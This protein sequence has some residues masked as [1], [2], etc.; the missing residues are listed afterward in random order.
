M[1]QNI[2]IN[3]IINDK[4]C[5]S[6]DIPSSIQPDFVIYQIR[7]KKHAIR[8]NTFYL[9]AN[10]IVIQMAKKRGVSIFIGQG[11][12]VHISEKSKHL[13]KVIQTLEHYNIIYIHNHKFKIKYTKLP[14]TG[15][16]SITFKFTENHLGLDWTPIDKDLCSNT[17]L[18]P[19]ICGQFNHSPI[20][21]RRNTVLENLNGCIKFIVRKMKNNIY[22]IECPAN[23]DQTIAFALGICQI[24]GPF[25]IIDSSS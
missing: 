21:S 22:E 16:Y 2:D 20:P 4:I 5:C 14:E 23:L 19:E 25:E 17:K 10:N 15:K 7:L 6:K 24:V 13:G 1:S 3:A 8:A 12:N 11:H 18:C 9:M